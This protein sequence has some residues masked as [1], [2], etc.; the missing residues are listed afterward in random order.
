ME[1]ISLPQ[2]PRVIKQEGNRV[3]FEIKPCYPGYGVNIGNSLRRVILGSLPG[4]AITAVKIKGVTHEFSTIPYVLEDVVQIIL[5]LKEIRIKL[6]SEEPVTVSLKVKGEKDVRASDIEI[7]S[8]VEIVNKNA[9]IATL[10]DKKAELE[11]EIRLE[12]GRGYVS[13][14]QRVK[15]KLE[16]GMI[17]VDAIFSPVRKISYEVEDMRVGER[18]DY[19]RLVFDIE[20]DGSITAQEAL[21]QAAKILS[22]HFNMLSSVEKETE[23]TVAKEE[24]KIGSDEEISG[25]KKNYKISDLKLSA[26]AIKTLEENKIKNMSSLVKKSE[27]DLMSLEGLGEKAVKEIK[28]ALGK[29]GVSLKE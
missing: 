16:I 7:T 6:Y 4:A 3:V 20:T 23:E 5:N 13:V 18:T 28:K 21:T 17:A 25:D 1:Q 2:K 12:K 8:D 11:M 9:H 26:R 24:K 27:S 22:D 19:N 10:T 14:E 15:E 29:L